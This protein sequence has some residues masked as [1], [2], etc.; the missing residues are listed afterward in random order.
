MCMYMCLYIYV[1]HLQPEPTQTLSKKDE[2]VNIYLHMGI[3]S[4]D[5]DLGTKGSTPLMD[6]NSDLFNVLKVQ[7]ER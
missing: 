1:Q 3:R 7:L 5:R 6:D 2:E 4:Q